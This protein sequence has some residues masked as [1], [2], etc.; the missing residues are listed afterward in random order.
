ME[1]EISQ[2]MGATFSHRQSG[3]FGSKSFHI[4]I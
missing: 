2:Y 1:M 4:L 3:S